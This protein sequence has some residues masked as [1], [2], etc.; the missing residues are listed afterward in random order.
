[1]LE[2]NFGLGDN[3]SSQNKVVTKKGLF[4]EIDW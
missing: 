1:M 2:S 3:G 4:T